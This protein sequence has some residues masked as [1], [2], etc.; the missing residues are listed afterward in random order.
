L[1]T[2]EVFSLSGGA[3]LGVGVFCLCTRWIH[4]IQK[5]RCFRRVLAAKK[6]PPSEADWPRQRL[7]IPLFQRCFPIGNRSDASYVAIDRAFFV[8]FSWV[9]TSDCVQSLGIPSW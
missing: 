9:T 2:K 6:D 4:T 3:G 7:I 1:L 8:G 5:A